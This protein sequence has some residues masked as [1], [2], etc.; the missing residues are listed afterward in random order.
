MRRSLFC[1][2]Q[3]AHRDPRRRRSSARGFTLIELMVTMT[4]LAILLSIAAPSFAR[5]MA[6]NRLTTETNE[7]IGSLN[8]ARGEAVRRAQPVSIAASSA[9]NYAIGWKIFPDSNGDGAPATTATDTDGNTLREIPA[10][11]G[12]PTV[13]RQAC[14]GTAPCT[15][16]TSTDSDRGYL[17][18]TERGALKVG[19]EVRFKVCDPSNTAVLGRMVKVAI[20]GTVSLQSTTVACP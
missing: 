2:S 13:T 3:P 16:A 4:V 6:A 15:W 11:K 9:A 12:T 20:V 7:L 14:T 8:L 5:L 1:L 18:F 17:V 19:K 10:F